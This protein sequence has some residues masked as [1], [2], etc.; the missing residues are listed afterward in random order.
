[1]LFNFQTFIADL[2]ENQ[3]KKEV[4]E[5]FEKHFGLIS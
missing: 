5:K 4:V 3:E 2:R 1:M